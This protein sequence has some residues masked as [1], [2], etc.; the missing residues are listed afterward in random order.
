MI[1]DFG[2]EAEEVEGVWCWTLE[3]VVV[4][5]EMLLI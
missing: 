5:D 1:V 3:E 2:E 4:N